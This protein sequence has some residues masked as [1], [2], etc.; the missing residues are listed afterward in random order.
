MKTVRETLVETVKQGRKAEAKPY[1]MVEPGCAGC[2]TLAA[3]LRELM[4]AE[5][6]EPGDTYYQK[7][8]WAKAVQALGFHGDG[9]GGR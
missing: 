8:A 2:G 5:G 1:R 9:K 7:K 4:D 6:G 3:A